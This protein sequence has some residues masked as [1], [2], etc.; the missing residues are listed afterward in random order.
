MLCGM[1]MHGVLC[2]DNL[3]EESQ[4]KVE[5]CGV[6][7][8]ERCPEGTGKSTSSTGCQPVLD[9][10]YSQIQCW[11]FS[12]QDVGL[13]DFLR[14]PSTTK[15]GFTEQPQHTFR[16]HRLAPTRQRTGFMQLMKELT[17][18]C[19]LQLHGREPPA[20]PTLHT[21]AQQRHQRQHEGSA[22]HTLSHMR[23]EQAKLGKEQRGKGQMENELIHGREICRHPAFTT[24]QLALQ[25]WN[26]SGSLWDL[27]R[28]P[29]GWFLRLFHGGLEMRHTFV[30]FREICFESLQAIKLG[31]S[32]HIHIIPKKHT[33]LPHNS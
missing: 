17:G 4:N 23:D 14:S 8:M 33:A 9:N 25:P 18:R 24:P 12:E 6:Q 16:E 30:L 15:L 32:L 31:L 26:G 22:Q 20:P 2:P 3:T 19:I 13:D 11:L 29:Q 28:R 21:R 1:E 5:K 7:Q 27:T 10:N